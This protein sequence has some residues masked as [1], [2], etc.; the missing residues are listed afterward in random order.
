MTCKFH[1]QIPTAFKSSINILTQLLASSVE[2]KKPCSA[3]EGIDSKLVQDHSLAQFL[4]F[5]ANG[6]SYIDLLLCPEKNSLHQSKW[7]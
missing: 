7:V 3:V 5:K 4:G 1:V 6:C 2:N